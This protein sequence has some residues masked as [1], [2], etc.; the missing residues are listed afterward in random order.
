MVY[1]TRKK[2]FKSSVKK[3]NLVSVFDVIRKLRKNQLWTDTR[4]LCLTF[5]YLEIDIEMYQVFWKGAQTNEQLIF[6]LDF[7]ITV[8]NVKVFLL[9]AKFKC[10][11]S[12]RDFS[13]CDIMF[14]SY[15]CRVA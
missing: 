1:Y 11:C 15:L 3:K 8:K 5:K 13:T 9:L 7:L 2:K 14:N 10:D 6:F 12:I 4:F